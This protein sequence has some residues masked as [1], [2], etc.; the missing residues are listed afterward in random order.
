MLSANTVETETQSV[1]L[2]FAFLSTV[3]MHMYL[4]QNLIF[5]G[6]VGYIKSENFET[7]FLISEVEVYRRRRKFKSILHSLLIS[8]V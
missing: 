1:L 3:V 2:S 5:L 8:G 7:A 4:L 6:R